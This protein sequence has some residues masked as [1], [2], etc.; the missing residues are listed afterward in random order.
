MPALSFT[1]AEAVTLALLG[2]LIALAIPLGVR[3]WRRN[4]I[5]PEERE[6]QR[7]TSLA[8]AGKITDATLV[9]IREDALFYSYLVRGMEYTASQDVT[10]L[11]PYLPDEFGLGIGPVSVKYDAQNPANSIVVA[12]QWSGLRTGKAG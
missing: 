6:R 8:T 10:T 11:K 3:A 4:R 1:A 9:E 5:T 2:A 7:R 12:E